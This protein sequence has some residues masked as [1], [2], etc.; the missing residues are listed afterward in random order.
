V[1]L[2]SPATHGLLCVPDPLLKEVLLRLLHL[3]G[4]D[5]V[6]SDTAPVF[7]ARLSDPGRCRFV[8]MGGPGEPRRPGQPLQRRP[9]CLVPLPSKI[10]LSPSRPSLPSCRARLRGGRPRFPDQPGGFPCHRRPP[11]PFPP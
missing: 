3:E 5:V 7:L 9:F 2:D 4:L 11:A 8:A 6:V 1:R 10:D